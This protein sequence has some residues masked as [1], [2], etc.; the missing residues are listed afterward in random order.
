MNYIINNI[1]KYHEIIV[2]NDTGLEI[3]FV[4]YGASVY[5]I[6]LNGVLMNAA[7]KNITDYLTLRSYYGKTL[8]RVAGRIKDATYTLSNGKTLYLEKN[9]GKN[10]TMGGF[11]NFTY[12]V[13]DFDIKQ[14]DEGIF[15]IFKLHSPDQ[16]AGYNGNLNVE[17]NYFVPKNNNYVEI[18]YRA[19][20][21]QLTILNLSN[22]LYFNIA[23]SDDVLD[24]DCYL[25]ADKVGLMDDELIISKYIDVPNYLDFRTAKRIGRDIMNPNLHKPTLNGY[26][27]RYLFNKSNYDVVKAKLSTDKYEILGYSTYDGMILYSNGKP[28]DYLLMDNSVDHQYKSITLEFMNSTPIEINPNEQYEQRTKYVFK[29]K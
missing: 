26:D 12:K 2:N 10:S 9:N 5:Y 18:I 16:E 1:D 28:K 3:S 8:G 21:D 17:I 15:V 13:F 19:I 14:T 22:H 4:D 20:S 25:D 29:E 24:Y 27:H 6:K 23:G 7:F 11:N